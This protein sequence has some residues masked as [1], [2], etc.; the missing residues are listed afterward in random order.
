MF[1]RYNHIG[2]HSKRPH[3]QNYA[4]RNYKNSIPKMHT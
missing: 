3:T 1:P 4:I 2:E